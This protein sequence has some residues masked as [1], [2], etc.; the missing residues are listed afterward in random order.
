MEFFHAYLPNHPN[1]TTLILVL[2]TY[3]LPKVSLEIF[4]AYTFQLYH[5]THIYKTYDYPNGIEKCL[6]FQNCLLHGFYIV[7]GQLT[8]V[9]KCVHYYNYHCMF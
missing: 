1:I 8:A 4:C 3:N 6:L 2:D 9:T 5:A 7:S